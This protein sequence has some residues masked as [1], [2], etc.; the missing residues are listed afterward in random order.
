MPARAP[1]AASAEP[2]LPADGMAIFVTPSSLA[3]ETA[4]DSPRALKLPVGLSPSSFI[5]MRLEPAW[6]CKAS[7]GSSGVVPSPSVTMFASSRTGMS[8]NQRHMLPVRA[9]SVSLL[10]PRLTAFRS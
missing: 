7:A 10:K 6:R 5:Q 2:A 1:Y 3:F 9:A 4:A 8:S